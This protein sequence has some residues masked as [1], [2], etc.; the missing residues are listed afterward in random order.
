MSINLQGMSRFWW[1]TFGLF[2]SLAAHAETIYTH[3]GV[4]YTEIYPYSRPCTTSPAV[5]CIDYTMSMSLNGY[6]ATTLPLRP[7][8]DS[9]DVSAQVI[10]YEFTDG[11][12]RYSSA[13]IDSRVHMFLVS[14]DAQGNINAAF[15][16]I[17]KWLTGARPHSV[18]DRYAYM[19]ISRF[20]NQAYSNHQCTLVDVSPS[21][22]SDSC[23]IGAIDSAMSRSVGPVGT[24]VAA[25]QFPQVPALFNGALWLL[26]SCLA[27]VGLYQAKALRRT[28]R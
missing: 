28:F 4:P 12:Y 20:A 15:V 10:R 21:G 19:V 5:E 27:V 11:I 25:T 7:N 16:F 9:A 24:W 8:L 17:E 1:L 22:A 14:T 13:D 18:E 3:A 23:E 26:V 6:F 2:W